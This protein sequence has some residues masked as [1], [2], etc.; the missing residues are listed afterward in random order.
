MSRQ[1]VPGY[2][3]V[4]KKWVWSRRVA[5]GARQPSPSMKGE[6]RCYRPGSAPMSKNL[7][8]EHPIRGGDG[9]DLKTVAMRLLDCKTSA[10]AEILLQELIDHHKG[11][12]R[13]LGD[14]PGNHG[15]VEVGG[16][17]DSAATERVT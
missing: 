2:R 17:S 9:M 13:P 10:A 15:A 8:M 12:F 7:L 4:Y 11:T 5:R 1:C 6:G 16:D 14:I 3:A